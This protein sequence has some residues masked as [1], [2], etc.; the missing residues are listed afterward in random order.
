MITIL[1]YVFRIAIGLVY[2]PVFSFLYIG[3]ECGVGVGSEERKVYSPAVAFA[4]NIIFRFTNLYGAT[5]NLYSFITKRGIT[6]SF[7]IVKCN[8]F[9]LRVFFLLFFFFNLCILHLHFRFSLV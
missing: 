2:D 6:I 7:H 3:G 1:Q 5:P 4:S 8:K 9:L